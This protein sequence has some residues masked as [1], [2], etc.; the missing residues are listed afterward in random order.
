M[1]SSHGTAGQAP[2]FCAAG[3][4]SA[5][6]ALAPCMRFLSGARRCGCRRNS[7]GFWR[8]GAPGDPIQMPSHLNKR[9]WSRM[10][11]CGLG[12]AAAL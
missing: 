12:M 4:L 3:L 1:E 2:S 10:L 7:G 6:V 5:A 9:G 8:S 11:L